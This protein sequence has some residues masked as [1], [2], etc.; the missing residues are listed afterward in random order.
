MKRQ[1][2]KRVREAEDGH[3]IDLTVPV[4]DLLHGARA[5]HQ[6]VGVAGGVNS[7]GSRRG[8]INKRSGGSA[9]LGPQGVQR[10]K[11]ELGFPTRYPAFM[12]KE[13][14]NRIGRSERLDHA[15]FNGSAGGYREQ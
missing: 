13:I 3:P 2:H 11:E 10:R 6:L 4:G 8:G 9:D 14:T 12:A 7:Q 15:R 1:A 5:A